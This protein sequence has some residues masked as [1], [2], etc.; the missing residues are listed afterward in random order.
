MKSAYGEFVPF[1]SHKK[2]NSCT[3]FS[4]IYIFHA[5]SNLRLHKSRPSA[6]SMT[7]VY[8]IFSASNIDPNLKHGKTSLVIFSK[9]F[10]RRLVL[11][12]LKKVCHLM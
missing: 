2:C 5:I 8:I 1:Y 10:H 7:K 11:H 4:E 3:K 6:G 12:E 9:Q